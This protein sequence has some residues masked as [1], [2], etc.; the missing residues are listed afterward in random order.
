MA[1]WNLL[2]NSDSSHIHARFYTSSQCSSCLSATQ[3]S[4]LYVQLYVN[5]LEPLTMTQSAKISDSLKPISEL[6]CYLFL[7]WLSFMKPFW[8]LFDIS[9]KHNWWYDF[10]WYWF[11]NPEQGLKCYWL[12]I[13]EIWFLVWKW[14]LNFR[15]GGILDHWPQSTRSL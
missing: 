14:P 11:S 12:K 9:Y 2:L 6:N 1:I 8:I 10:W 5:Q 3:L 7:C 15:Q 4:N 13:Q